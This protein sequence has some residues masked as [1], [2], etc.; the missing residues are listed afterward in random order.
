M[1]TTSPA[2]KELIYE[3]IPFNNF[4]IN[5]TFIIIII[6]LGLILGLVLGLVLKDNKSSHEKAKEHIHHSNGIP[7]V[8]KVSR[9]NYQ[10]KHILHPKAGEAK[11]NC[12]E[13]T[14]GTILCNANNF[15]PQNNM[16]TN[17]ENCSKLCTGSTNCETFVYLESTIKINNETKFCQLFKDVEF[18]TSSEPNENIKSI[19]VYDRELNYKSNE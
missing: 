1:T 13:K 10:I 18:S 14:D 8:H 12:A 4:K 9:Q 15:T 7:N 2:L 19:V 3:G 5:G 16:N 6:V 17:I 11:V